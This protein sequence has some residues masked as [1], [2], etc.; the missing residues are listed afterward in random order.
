MRLLC[1]GRHEYLSVHLCR[2]FERLGVEARPAVGLQQAAQIAALFSP[3][4][5]VCDYDLLATVPLDAWENDALLSK[6]PVLAVSLTR[7]R[8]E[9]PLLDVKGIAGFLY[10]PTLH[11]DDAR[12]VLAATRGRV[13]IVPPRSLGISLPSAPQ[14]V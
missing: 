12:Q 2:V 5:A 10:L 11:E 6:V 13:G 14:P 1:V 8:D 9:I 7:R 4:A 3:D